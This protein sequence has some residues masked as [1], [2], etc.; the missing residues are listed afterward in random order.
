MKWMP[1][2]VISNWLMVLIQ[3]YRATEM[4]LCVQSLLQAKSIRSDLGTIFPSPQTYSYTQKNIP[5]DFYRWCRRRRRWSTM[6]KWL[7]IRDN[8]IIKIQ[9]TYTY[10]EKTSKQL[11]K[12]DGWP[13]RHAARVCAYWP[14]RCWTSS[15][16]IM[17]HKRTK[18]R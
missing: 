7:K 4:C 6:D 12:R 17:R 1:S 8:K 18:F 10:P 3:I 5:K 15:N 11:R 16:Q 2:K 13:N 14:K 9:N